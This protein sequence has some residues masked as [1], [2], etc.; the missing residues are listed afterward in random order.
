M[1]TQFHNYSILE[2]RSTIAMTLVLT[3][4]VRSSSNGCTTT[5]ENSECID[6]VCYGWGTMWRCVDMNQNMKWS[7]LV[8]IGIHLCWNELTRE[9][10]YLH[11]NKRIDLCWSIG[12]NYESVFSLFT[13]ETGKVLDFNLRIYRTTKVYLTAWLSIFY[14]CSESQSTFLQPK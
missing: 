13:W 10:E 5:M 4:M 9:H 2:K 1:Q 6:A 14:D 11:W 8:W 7:K 3:Q 12:T